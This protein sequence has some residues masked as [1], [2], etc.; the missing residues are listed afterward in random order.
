MP[1]HSRI[2]API[3]DTLRAHLIAHPLILEHLFELDATDF[4]FEPPPLGLLVVRV[5]DGWWRSHDE[6]RELGPGVL[7]LHPPRATDESPWSRSPPADRAALTDDVELR[8]RFRGLSVSPLHV[9]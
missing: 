2:L 6:V 3:D 7:D 1:E 4:G 9:A 8:A 5:P